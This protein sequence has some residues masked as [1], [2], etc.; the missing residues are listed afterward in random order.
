MDTVSASP[1][2]RAGK[3]RPTLGLRHGLALCVGIVIGAGIFRAPAMVAGA[4][5]S[6]AMFLGTWALGGLLSILGALCYAELASAHP[7]AGGDFHFLEVAFGRDLAFLYGWAR[8]AVIQTGSLALLAYVFGDYVAA[9]LPLG[10]YSSSLY[11]TLLVVGL[12]GLN[13]L[14]IRQGAGTQFWMTC[15]EVLGLVCVIVAGLVVAPE[16]VPTVRAPR[17]GA[18]GLVLVFVLLTY[19]G[20]S[21]VVYISAELQNARRRIAPVMV[22]G[23]G[24]VTLLYLLVN[25]AYLRALGLEGVAGSQ[26]VAA[27]VMA[28]AFGPA[29]GAAISLMIAIA[30]L[31]SANATV[32]TGART[33]YALGCAF[34]RLRWLGRWSA[35][36]D[37][38]GNAMLLQGII[39]VLLVIGATFGRDA[40]GA[41][42][43]YTAPVFWFFLL[44]VGIALFVL[45]RRSPPP[46]DCF[47]VPL[48]PLIPALF[49]ATSAYLLYSSIAYT[50]IS[51]LVGVGV[52]AIG[53]VLLL[54]LRGPTPPAV[55]S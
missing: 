51:A 5:S 33:N 9:L 21:E 14:G 34:P 26:T 50:G 36:R 24:L 2:D 19:G 27:D 15:A 29:G 43:E 20:W 49:C 40:F 25:W 37:T 1:D 10:A 17:E 35:T 52:L 55:R 45:R 32:I 31:T 48:Y 23:L 7:S 11:A 6:E 28:R 4:A 38:P 13:W 22:A 47:R 44:M 12:T 39:A 8:L 53:G 54:V 18:L 41:V 30:A 42:V 46:P 16:A 3:P